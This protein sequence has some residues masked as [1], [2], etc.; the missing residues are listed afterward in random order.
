MSRRPRRLLSLVAAGLL[1]VLAACGSNDTTS[2]PDS[3]SSGDGAAAVTNSGASVDCSAPPALPSSV[4]TFQPDD[5]PVADQ[6]G[7]VRARVETS[8][9]PI[10]LDLD[11]QSA[12]QTVSSFVFLAQ[13]G[14][15]RDSPC[16]RLTTE[17]IYVLQCGDPTGTGRG[18]PGYTFGIENAPADG[19][20]PRGTVAMARS[21]APDSNGGQFFIV[22]SDTM[23]PADGGGYTIFGKV[24][25][26][27]DIIDRVASEGVD[28]GGADG[29]P[30]QPISITGVEIEGEASSS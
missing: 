18:G 24:T 15:W 20:Y 16:H 19:L 21:S 8:C 9:G 10:T 17:G 29:V 4:P 1:T 22:H 26:G 6:Q 27:M 11:A 30:A 3:P 14:Y 2:T 28:G 12:P 23:L 7:P 13:E 5:A 25:E